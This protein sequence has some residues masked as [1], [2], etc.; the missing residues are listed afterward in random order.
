MAQSFWMA[1]F[2]FAGCFAG[3]TVISLATAR[4]RTDEELRGLVYSLTERVT[5]DAATS[6]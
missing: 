4:T 3:T 5:D 1:I 6:W 2:A